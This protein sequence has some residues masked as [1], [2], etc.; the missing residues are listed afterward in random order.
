MSSNDN[1]ISF[2]NVGI[3]KFQTQ[4]D[5]LQKSL[6]PIGILTP[7]QYGQQGQGLFQMSFDLRDQI[8]DNFRNLVLT[9]WGERLGIYDLGANLQ[10]L[11]SEYSNKDDFDSEAMVRINT[12]VSKYMPFIT[13]IGFS[14]TP[15][16]LGDQS[17]VGKISIII[18]YNVPDLNITEKS[19]NVILN[20]M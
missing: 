1:T 6:I 3:K 20:V 11:T 7:V 4:N 9:N 19:L 5:L 10:P 2:K 17:A 13:L 15:I 16:Y 14:S 12:A 18:I 8:Q